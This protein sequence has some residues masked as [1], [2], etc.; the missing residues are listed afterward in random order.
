MYPEIKQN[1]QRNNANSLVAV[2]FI[3]GRTIVLT[4][5]QYFHAINSAMDDLNIKQSTIFQFPHHGS[6]SNFNDY[7]PIMPSEFYIISGTPVNDGENKLCANYNY[8]QQC[9]NNIAEILATVKAK[10]RIHLIVTQPRMS[11]ELCHSYIK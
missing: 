9:Q 6:L 11:A 5:D 8:N 10:H 2:V 7:K 4:G 1:K 3:D